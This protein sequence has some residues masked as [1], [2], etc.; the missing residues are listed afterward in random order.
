MRQIAVL[1]TLSLTVFS[2]CSSHFDHYTL[3]E[4]SETATTSYRNVRL[5]T[6]DNKT[7]TILSTIFLNDVYP[8]YTDGL[9][10]FLVAFYSPEHNNTL[11][12]KRGEMPDEKA[13][14]L[15]LNGKEAL[16]SELLDNDDMLVKLLPMN[17]NWNRYYYVRYELPNATPV[18]ELESGHTEQAV[19]TYQKAQE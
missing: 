11:Y 8:K 12:F 4:E 17:N 6:S 13:Y 10:H 7:K 1:L 18:L 19:I 16:A 2:G 9:A 5:L 14:L 15:L 3:S